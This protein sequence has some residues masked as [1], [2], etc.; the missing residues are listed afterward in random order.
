MTR[1]A[2]ALRTPATERPATQTRVR[3]LAESPWY[4]L[5][6]RGARDWLRHNQ[7]VRHA[8]RVQIADL[9]AEGDFITQPEERTVRV[10][11]R[12]LDHAR[13][14]LAEPQ[15]DRGAGQ[16]G[17]QTGDTLRPAGNLPQDEGAGERGGGNE[18]GSFSLE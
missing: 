17:A 16:G 15:K 13:F 1:R 6:S 8:V 9:F 3:F 7:K 12:L 5:F 4:E 18:D 11:I 10:P 2:P 14:R